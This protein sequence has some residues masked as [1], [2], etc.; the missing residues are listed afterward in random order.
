MAPEI[1]LTITRGETFEFG[2]MYADED[3]R[4][5]PITGMPSTAP[6]RLTVVGHQVPEG[7]PVRIECVKQPMELNTPE[8]ETQFA[9]VVD[10]DTIE[11]NEVNAHCWRPFSGTGLMI[12]RAPMDLT[13]WHFRAQ[14]RDRV[15]GNLLF[16]WHS[17]P[18][19][20]PDGLVIVDLALSQFVLTMEAAMAGA[21]TWNRGVYDA[22]AIDPSGRVYK[23]A[24]ISPV[25]VTGEVTV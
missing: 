9:R 12:L 13:G 14:V 16:S 11:L 1:P 15:G 23:V 10:A 21:I 19:E 2:I 6:A 22:E 18:A 24:A 7:W 20:Q 3:L 17:D 4:Y 25:E 8:D 5:L